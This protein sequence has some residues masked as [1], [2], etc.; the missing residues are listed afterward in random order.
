MRRTDAIATLESGIRIEYVVAEP[1]D[2]DAKESLVLIHG[3]P[4][5]KCVNFEL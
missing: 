2:G 5:T 3:Y 1:D 4:Q